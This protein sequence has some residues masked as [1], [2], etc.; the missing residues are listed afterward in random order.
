MQRIGPPCQVQGG[1]ADR[2]HPI[3]TPVAAPAR[4]RRAAATA[5]RGGTRVGPVFD[6][7]HCRWSMAARMREGGGGQTKFA[8]SAVSSYVAPLAAERG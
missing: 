5:I 4:R 8:C 3:S 1:E 7:P 6:G 2:A